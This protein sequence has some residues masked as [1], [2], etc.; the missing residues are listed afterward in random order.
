MRQITIILVGT[1]ICLYIS[2]CEILEQPKPEENVELLTK[3]K[4]H[5]SKI[6]YHLSSGDSTDLVDQRL[7][8][9]ELDNYD[10][11]IAHSVWF[12]SSNYIQYCFGNK[13]CSSSE[14]KGACSSIGESWSVNQEQ[15]SLITGTYPYVISGINNNEMTL[16]GI[17]INNVPFDMKYTN[18]Q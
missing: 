10:E 12:T 2:S 11:Y 13:L 1:L 15:D 3:G 6:T 5:L 8:A 14:Q 17:G 9:C 18:L 4:W 16:S 7:D